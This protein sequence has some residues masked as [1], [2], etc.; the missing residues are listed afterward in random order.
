MHG[1]P[2]PHGLGYVHG[3]GLELVGQLVPGRVLEVD[4]PDHLP[5]KER[6]HGIQDLR[7]APQHPDPVGPSILC[8]LHAKK[9]Q[10]KEAT[11]TGMWGAL[12][13]PSTNISA[14]TLCASSASLSTGLTVPARWRSGYSR[15]FGS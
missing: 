5:A 3:P 1:R 4:L 9:S 8:P 11:S 15:P 14:S 7:L 12:C 10:P 2:E 6:V 13:A